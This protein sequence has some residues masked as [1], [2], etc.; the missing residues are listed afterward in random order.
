K[1]INVRNVWDIDNVKMTYDEAIKFAISKLQIN[2]KDINII[3][4]HQFVTGAKTSDSEETTVGGLDN[5]EAAAYDAFDYVALGHIHTKQH[6]GRESLCYCGTP[7]KYSFSEV[8]IEKCTLIVDVKGKNDIQFK[9]IPLK[10]L[11]DMRLL[12]GSYNDITSR[13]Y[14]KN[15]N[16]EDYVKAVLSDDI[17]IPEAINRLR[18]IYPNI[19]ALEYKNKRSAIIQDIEAHDENTQ[20][21]PLDFYS[22]LHEAQNNSPMTTEQREYM[23]TLIQNIW[24]S[25]V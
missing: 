21:S 12:K 13:D 15:T 4:S 2:E 17:E 18:Q 1:P 25:E 8:N 11:R 24:E 19:M 9:A 14:Y 5:I 22:Q 20:I 6:I 10:P 23:S 3:L 16:T 7:L